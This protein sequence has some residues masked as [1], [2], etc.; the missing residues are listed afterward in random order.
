MPGGVGDG[1]AAHAGEDHARDDVDVAE[2][3]PDAPDGGDTEPQ[4]P[5][6]DG[7]GVHDVGGDD[8]ER[9]GQQHEAAVEALYQLLDGKPDV[10]TGHREI[11]QRRE[12]HRKARSACRWP[13][14][15]TAREDT[16]RTAKLIC[17]GSPLPPSG[18]RIS[19][20]AYLGMILRRALASSR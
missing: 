3:A 5:L 15:E 12:D 14:A 13:P 1:A 10:L 7:A 17:R 8:E 11:N 19:P 9:H 4:Q 16:A 2:P 18:G 20:S 6:A